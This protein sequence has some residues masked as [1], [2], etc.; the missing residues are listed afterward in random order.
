LL[1]G[2]ELDSFM[3]LYRPS[4]TFTKLA[5]EYEFQYY[6]KTAFFRFKR[7]LRQEGILNKDE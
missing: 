1:D 4:Y 2:A 3:L 6:I 5:G 7:G